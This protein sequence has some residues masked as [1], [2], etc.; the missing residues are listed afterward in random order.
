MTGAEHSRGRASGRGCADPS[1]AETKRALRNDR[2]RRYRERKTLC[3]A[4]GRFLVTE[5]L[6]TALIVAGA[7][8]EREAETVAGIEQG[9]A[10]IL[11][12]FT[13]NTA[14]L[15]LRPKTRSKFSIKN[16]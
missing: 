9:V 13:C 16:V 8:N 2:Q 12:R 11:T 4:V 7:I 5:D 6:V 1:A 3:Q 15:L 10:T 14:D